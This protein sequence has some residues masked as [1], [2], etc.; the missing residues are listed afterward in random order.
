MSK[1]A[2]LAAQV[3]LFLPVISAWGAEEELPALDCVI[4][5][6][7]VI[8]LSSQIDGI[9]DT[10]YVDRGDLVQS[11][12]PLVK[13]ESS[14]EEAAVQS[15]KARANATAQ[16][17]SGEV[18]A[19]FAERRKDRVQSL[20]KEQAV[21]P[22]QMDETET[23]KTLSSLQFDQA[24]E[25][26]RIA[27]LELRQAMATLKRHTIES[28]V[29]GV[30]V[31]RY[32][33]P[34]ESVK[35]Q[36]IMR[37][38]QIDPLRVE[39]IV[40]VSRFGEIEVGQSAV[41][42]PE[43]PKAGEYPATVTVVDRVADAASGTFRVRLSLPNPDHSV[44]SG[45]KCQVQISPDQQ[46]D[47]TQKLA[48]TP[49]AAQLPEQPQRQVQEKRPDVFIA[50][51]E[52]NADTLPSCRT[53][54]PIKNA[55]QAKQIQAA[56]LKKAQHVELRETVMGEDPGYIILSPDALPMDAAKTLAADMTA[57]GVDDLFVF[58]RGKYKGHVSLGLYKS[59][60]LA[61]ERIGKV[62]AAGFTAK[63]IPRASKNSEYWLDMA[64]AN[65]ADALDS[66][67]MTLAPLS[68]AIEASPL[69]CEKMVASTQ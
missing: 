14:V 3:M 65:N 39:V 28:P 24:K 2:R 60:P 16:L 8:D 61:Q 23:Q 55:T 52:R 34:G 6:H 19:G 51:G 64:I 27:K 43:P 22:D 32:L 42:R 54:G 68:P 25:N 9:V 21:S 57:A 26:R 53:V 49:S 29:D 62:E 48:A 56:L 50:A 4:E 18:S 58:H 66:V 10:V 17:R 47:A 13:L 69:P 31:Q 35:D 41:V 44:P 12:Q 67:A 20:Y 33:S 36:P 30:V 59:E 37:L 15:A 40:P 7:M 46:S 63:L 5:P 1:N 38:A 45:L 11:S